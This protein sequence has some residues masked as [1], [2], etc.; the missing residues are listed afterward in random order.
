MVAE[1][2]SRTNPEKEYNLFMTDAVNREL[3]KVY[4][5]KIQA[6][7]KIKE[8]FYWDMSP[9]QALTSGKKATI[10]TIAPVIED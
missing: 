3:A 6:V 7:R 8:V 1:I 4:A 9:V 2:E 5:E 10:A